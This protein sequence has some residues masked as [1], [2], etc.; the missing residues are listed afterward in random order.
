MSAKIVIYESMLC[1]Y[2]RAAKRLLDNKGWEYETIGVDARPA[3]RREMQEKS[4]RTSVPQ[5]WFD[6]L[7]VGGFDDMAALEADGKLDALY[8]AK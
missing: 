8:E 7:H 6:D 2:C 5:I 1:G 4:G 3:K